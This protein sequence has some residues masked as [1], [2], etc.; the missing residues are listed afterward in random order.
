[1][2]DGIRTEVGEQGM[3][4][5]GGQAQ[6]VALARAFLADRPL[7]LLDEPT[8]QVDLA[9]EAQIVD[10]IERLSAGRTVVMVSHRS[11]ALSAADRVVT[12]EAGG[13]R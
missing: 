8:S 12:V 1:M 7:L 4:L 10:A 6:R 11:G 5:S 2:P 9:G 13:L 3:G